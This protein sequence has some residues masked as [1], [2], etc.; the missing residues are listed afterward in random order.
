M[1][2]ILPNGYK[3]FNERRRLYDQ[4][5]TFDKDPKWLTEGFKPQK[6]REIAIADT[7]LAWNVPP[8][9]CP[10]CESTNA[11]PRGSCN[12]FFD[13]MVRSHCRGQCTP[14][15]GM[16]VFKEHRPDLRM[17][18]N[19]VIRYQRCAK[20]RHHN[21]FNTDEASFIC[22]QDAWEVAASREQDKFQEAIEG[23]I[24]TRISSGDEPITESY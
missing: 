15:A 2:L 22:P 8:S 7:R 11:D 20:C 4:R 23:F 13:G 5:G 10:S 14:S 21:L 18:P 24:R 9:F 19:D 17:Q 6:E 12:I 16:F 1:T 3:E